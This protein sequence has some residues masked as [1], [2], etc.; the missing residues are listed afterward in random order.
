MTT[1]SPT[2]DAFSVLDDTEAG[3]STVTSSAHQKTHQPR[4]PLEAGVTTYA[5]VTYGTVG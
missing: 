3:A 2:P 1:M 4:A 5:L